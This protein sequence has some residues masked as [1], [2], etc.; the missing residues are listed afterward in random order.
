VRSI[1][2]DQARAGAFQLVAVLPKP[3]EVP[4][5]QALTKDGIPKWIV[6]C[7]HTPLAEGDFASKAALEEIV[8]TAH[9]MPAIQPL[10]VL[11]FQ[12]LIARHWSMSGR[13]GVS[14]S[15]TAVRA[16]QKRNDA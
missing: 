6:Q 1:P 13:S 10:M 2:I 14:F 9:Q 3:G 4:G 15:A 7:L 12:D 5:V 8:V 11:Q 16:V